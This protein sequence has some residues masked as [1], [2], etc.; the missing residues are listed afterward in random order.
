MAQREPALVTPFWVR[1]ATETNLS[2]GW[3]LVAFPAVLYPTYL[4]LE[5]LFGRGLAAATDFAG[6]LEAWMVLSYAVTLG[7]T[8]MMSTYVARG[9][10]RDLEALRPVL[11]G[12][13][14]KY[15]DLRKQF[16][17]FERRR[18]WMGALI[19]FVFFILS[20]ELAANRWTRFLAGDWSLR[21]TCIV[22]VGFAA[23]MVFWR[24]AVYLIDAARL[25]SR[26]GECHVEVDFLNL[27]PLSPLSRHGLRIVLLMTILVAF[28]VIA[29]VGGP[30][31]VPI[32]ATM[33]MFF[34]WVI[35]LVLATVV[36]VFP[37]RGLRRQIRARKAE[38]LSNLREKIRHNREIADG[39]GPE[40]GTAG[41]KL[42]GLL[43]YKHEIE[44]VREWPFDAPTLT[45][46][47]L[48]VAIPLGS[49][50][51]GAFVERLLG[52]ALD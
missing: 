2:P 16:A 49:W 48:Y 51:G 30:A 7:Y 21:A 50:I 9:T 41:A 22:V 23:L 4:L 37:V 8:S 42:P 36:F 45:R 34:T 27:A 11:Q 20:S 33:V 40:S 44:S 12:G 31:S 6:D 29:T 3:L 1:I 35:L 47:F 19:G 18:L 24:A 39:S 25:Y 38:E 32:S 5:A 28:S 10:F 46:F 26:V 15:L 13:E 52:A 43:A 14:A 17:R